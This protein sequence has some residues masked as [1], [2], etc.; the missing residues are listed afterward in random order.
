MSDKPKK[1]FAENLGEVLE[2]ILVDMEATKKRMDALE[3]KDTASNSRI[4]QSYKIME[5]VSND[6]GTLLD[7]VKS[8][9]KE[10]KT[11]VKKEIERRIP[12]MSVIDE[13][14]HKVRK[15]WEQRS[16]K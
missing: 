6:V 5:T 9:W 4:D 12:K 16:M 7:A 14:R 13:L 15:L 3:K 8:D 1:N 2:G 10:V 11:W